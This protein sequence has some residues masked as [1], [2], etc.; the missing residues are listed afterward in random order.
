MKLLKEY[1][2]SPVITT[3]GDTISVD[4]EWEGKKLVH[5]EEPVKART[6]NCARI[7][8]GDFDGMKDC[9]IVV[10]GNK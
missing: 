9:Y 4:I 2:F 1:L 3:K 8:E 6:F 5:H 7:Y 10:L